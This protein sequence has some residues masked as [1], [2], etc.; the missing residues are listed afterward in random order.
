[1]SNNNDAAI[2]RRYPRIPVAATFKLYTNI[3]RA[4]YTAQVTNMSRKGAFIQSKHLPE[5]GDVI[6]YCVI[7]ENGE[8]Y[9]AGNATVVWLK[10]EGTPGY[11]I[12]VDQEF[13][14]DFIDAM[15]IK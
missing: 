1:M 6:S 2:G 13:H 5:I 12:E 8:E 15:K 3:T 7:G 10:C 4:K 11:G 14:E 9:F